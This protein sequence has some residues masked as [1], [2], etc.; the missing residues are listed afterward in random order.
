M[1]SS[2]VDVVFGTSAAQFFGRLL[3]RQLP[4]DGSVTLTT[5]QAVDGVTPVVLRS[6]AVSL[7]GIQVGTFTCACF[8]FPAFATCGGTAFEVD[9]VPSPNCTVGFEG[10]ALC[11][12]EKPCAAVNGAGNAASGRITCGAAPVHVDAFQDCN[13]IPRAAPFPPTVSVE[14]GSNPG[15]AQLGNALLTAATA[16]GATTGSCLGSTADY[17]EDGRFC[18]ADDPINLRGTPIISMFGTEAT[19]S[20]ANRGDSE[21]SLFGPVPIQGAPFAC[22]TDGSIDIGG[23]GIATAYTICDYPTVHDTAIPMVLFFGDAPI[24]R[25]SALDF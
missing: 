7:D 10:A 17:G 4:L 14:H 8:R 20:I 15:V 12:A 18:T 16:L 3:H 19:V 11:P 6:D 23:A 9:G 13:G 25:A 22:G 21:G 1:F 24:E 5:G 2:D